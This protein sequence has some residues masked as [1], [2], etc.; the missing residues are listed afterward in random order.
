MQL[1]TGAEHC[2]NLSDVASLNVAVDNLAVV[3]HRHYISEMSHNYLCF[4]Q[5][6][7]GEE[8]GGTAF[9]LI[10]LYN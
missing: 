10:F 2:G 5:S 9:R 6:I 8:E 1:Q 7:A 4:I 3:K